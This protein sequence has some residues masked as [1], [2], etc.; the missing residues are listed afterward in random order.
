MHDV[1]AIKGKKKYLNYCAGNACPAK[2]IKNNI[3][4]EHAFSSKRLQAFHFSKSNACK[5]PISN[6]KTKEEGLA[7]E[8]KKNGIQIFIFISKKINDELWS[9]DYV[10]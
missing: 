8:K 9:N 5:F 6:L 2:K 4:R 3:Q 1:C 7:C 10:F